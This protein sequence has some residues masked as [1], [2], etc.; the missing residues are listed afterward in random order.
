MNNKKLIRTFDVEM[1]PGTVE[2]G[3]IT[4]SIPF[5]GFHDSVFSEYLTH[6]DY[7][8]EKDSEEREKALEALR[9]TGKEFKHDTITLPCPVSSFIEQYIAVCND[10][11]QFASNGQCP[12]I[13]FYLLGNEKL[14]VKADKSIEDFDITSL[15]CKGLNCNEAQLPFAILQEMLANFDQ[16]WMEPDYNKAF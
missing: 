15:L 9:S 11:L 1:E 13:A 10:A 4:F 14:F 6:Q 2:L 8:L 5:A 3:E 7:E 12:R 16:T